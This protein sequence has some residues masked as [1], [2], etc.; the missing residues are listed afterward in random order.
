[1]KSELLLPLA[2][3]L[4][5]SLRGAAVAAPWQSRCSPLRARPHRTPPASGV[6]MS[7]AQR[8][9]TRVVARSPTATAMA[10]EG[11]ASTPLA[12]L[13]LRM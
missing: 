9:T 5:L 7:R 12:C 4:L 1:M 13:S 6:G 2:R 8:T 10:A 3:R 11:L